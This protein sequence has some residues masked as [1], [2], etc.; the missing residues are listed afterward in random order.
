MTEKLEPIS[1][2][3]AKVINQQS[4]ISFLQTKLIL[5][6]TPTNHIYKRPAKGG[7]TWE[8]VTGA[9]VKNQLNRIF[10]YLWSFEIK[11][12]EIVENQAIVQG[13]LTVKMGYN[14]QTATFLEVCKEDFGRADIKKK[15]DG[16]GSLDI[17]SDLKAAATDCLKR[18]AF[19]IGIASD[20]YGRAE[21]QLLIQEIKLDLPPVEKTTVVQPAPQVTDLLKK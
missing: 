17:G 9:Y 7:G 4:P 13:K 21:H 16:T 14:P 3:E 10:G 6:K 12:K 20:V 19:Q 18:C 5:K 11:S 15:K 8:Y 2:F 1:A